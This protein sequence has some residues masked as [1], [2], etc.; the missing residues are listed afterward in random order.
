MAIRIPELILVLSSIYETLK[1]EEGPVE[2]D[3]RLCTELALN[4]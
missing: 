4:W 3:A 2:I 1:E